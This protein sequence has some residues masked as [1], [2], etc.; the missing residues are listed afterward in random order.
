MRP[1]HILRSLPPAP[2]R[3]RI[4]TKGPAGRLWDRERSAWEEDGPAL[5]LYQTPQ[6]P[7]ASPCHPTFAACR[8][9]RHRSH[10]LCVSVHDGALM[11]Q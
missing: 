1:L 7:H 9:R 8:G 6:A 4:G 3:L 5:L 2:A 11:S 10:L